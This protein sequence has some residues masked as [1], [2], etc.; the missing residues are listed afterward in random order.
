M[1]A[2]DYVQHVVKKKYTRTKLLQFIDNITV[3]LH[4]QT[5]N[6]IVLRIN[7]DLIN[8]YRRASKDKSATKYVILN[9]VEPIKI[10]EELAVRSNIN[11]LL[12]VY[13]T[14]SQK[15]DV[16]PGSANVSELVKLVRKQGAVLLSTYPFTG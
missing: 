2:Q 3:Y 6:Q 15:I 16:I 1:L 10:K 5:V 4:D 8:Q 12:L 11:D 7:D 14:R 13:N 9:D